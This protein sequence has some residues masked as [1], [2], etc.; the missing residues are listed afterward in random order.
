MELACCALILCIFWN[1]GIA[2]FERSEDSLWYQMYKGNAIQQKQFSLCF[3]Q[4]TVPH[5]PGKP[6]GVIVLGGT[7][8][9][10]NQEQMVYAQLVTDGPWF[11]IYVEAIYLELVTKKSD[12][13]KV[14]RIEQLQGMN[15]TQFNEGEIIIDSGSTDNYLPNTM[16][17]PLENAWQ[18][19]MGKRYNASKVYSADESYPNMVFQLKAAKVLDK[20]GAQ[21]GSAAAFDADRPNDVIIRMPPENFMIEE[22]GGYSS[23]YMDDDPEEGGI[24]GAQAMKGKNILFDD[25]NSRVGF[26]TSKCQ[27]ST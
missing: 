14:T 4:P 10:L 26:A 2:G 15:M 9:K 1:I 8:E 12:G 25:D 20:E 18:A 22:E 13:S 3:Q 11:T 7:D 27:V 5:L 19:L 23:L 6:A 21:V 16:R 17:K 24:L